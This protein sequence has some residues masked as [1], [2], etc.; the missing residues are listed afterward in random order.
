MRFLIQAGLTV[1]AVNVVAKDRDL[2]VSSTGLV[3]PLLRARLL[4]VSSSIISMPTR[5]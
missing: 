5:D 4:T 1:L 2:G 3:P